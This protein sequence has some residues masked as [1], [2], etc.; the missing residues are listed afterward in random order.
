MGGLS[1][2]I[3]EIKP[4][5]HK[6][7]SLAT[8]GVFITAITVGFLSHYFL[9]FTILESMLL[10]GIIS[11][12]DAAAVFSVL[13][14]KNISLKNNL[15]PLLEFESGSNDPMAVFLTVAIISLIT[16]ELKSVYSLIG[17]FF[18]QMLL[19]IICGYLI[20]KA[21]VWLINKIK[22]EYDGL[23]IVIT[24]ATVLMGYA[25][26]S[27]I[28]G[29]GFMSVYVCGLTMAASNFIHKNTLVKFHDGIAWIMQIG[30]FLILGLLVFMKEVMAVAVPGLIV[31]LILIFVA[32]PISVFIGLAPFKTPF[33]DKLLISW[34][35]LRGAAPIVLATFP[36]SSGIAHSHEIFNVVF[37]VVLVSVIVQGTTIP[38]A[39]KLLG[40]DAPMDKKYSSLLEYDTA[41]TNNKMIEF[42]V[43]KN[44]IAIGK[45]L[46]ELELPQKCLV[47]MVFRD[48]DYLIPSGTTE[49][50]E[51]DVLFVLMDKEFEPIVREKI[52]TKKS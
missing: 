3:N 1:V 49:I 32:R 22:L 45:R 2:N 47:A 33:R 41:Y 20:A 6:G 48:N 16:N 44:S 28:G 14:S 19:G 15:K 26:A 7:L 11:S 34:V 37:F 5:F 39:A 24:I 10:G 30:M 36:L 17:M 8:I 50:H 42:T 12:T 21:A 13:R 40:V 25:A 38:A 43:P 51:S 23:Y 4:I 29:N 46:F 27:L 35:G 9:D 18:Q 31:A 52:C